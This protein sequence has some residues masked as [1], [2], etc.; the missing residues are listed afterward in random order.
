MVVDAP[1]LRNA[2]NSTITSSND[3][4]ITRVGRVLRR[5][6]LDE[7]PQLL[8]VIKGDMSLV[9]PRPNMATTP[10]EVLSSIEKVR[11]KVR[12]GIT[13]YTQAHFRNSIST[14][15]KYE[16]D[17]IYVEN[18]TLKNDF[19]IILQ[20]LMSVVGQKGIHQD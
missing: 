2:D 4:R 7:L 14:A 8:N 12:P 10:Y 11:V 1:D 9:G 20:T 5:S 17:A 6:S 13:G 18:I 19:Q 3:P 16:H 15:E